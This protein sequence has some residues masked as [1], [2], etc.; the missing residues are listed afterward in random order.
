MPISIRIG[1]R[2][3]LPIRNRL[4]R[5]SWIWGK[6][7]A[8]AVLHTR[9]AI[10][11]LDGAV[12]HYEFYLSKD[13]RSWTKAAEGEFSNIRNSPIVQEVHLANPVDARYFKFVATRTLDNAKYVVI[14]ELGIFQKE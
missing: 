13:V 12:S 7:S 1:I 10:G 8:W 11:R 6:K 2:G 3:W 4:R 5:S 9:R 14:T